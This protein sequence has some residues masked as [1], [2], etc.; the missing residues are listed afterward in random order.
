[1]KYIFLML[2]ILSISVFAQ[3]KNTI[4][5]N[6]V[7]DTS[8]KAD[9]MI[10]EI[11]VY[12]TDS[13]SVKAN[14]TGHKNLVDVLDVLRKFGYKD[15]EIYLKESNFQN[16][17][18]DKPREFSAL[19]TYRIILSKFD[20]FDQLKKDVIDAGATGVRIVALWSS[21]YKEIKK[22]LYASAIAEAKEKAQFLSKQMGLKHIRFSQIDDNSVDESNNADISFSNPG[23]GFRPMGAMMS[24]KADNIAPTITN[25]QFLISVSLRIVF[26]FD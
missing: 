22:D 21:R 13:I 19:Q 9:E 23:N 4:S 11:S 17:I 5:L 7:K 2:T 3:S 15:S 14:D 1:M 25:G 24:A 6:A 8:V 26:N 16:N 10:L 20:L 18:Y 12:K